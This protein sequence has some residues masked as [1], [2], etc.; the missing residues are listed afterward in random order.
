MRPQARVGDLLLPAAE[1]QYARRSGCDCLLDEEGVLALVLRRLGKIVDTAKG[2]IF[3]RSSEQRRV[4]VSYS[5][6]VF[7]GFVLVRWPSPRY[8][9]QSDCV[10]IG[11]SKCFLP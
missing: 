7:H 4:K 5:S 2:N 11:K 3:Y 9:A 8:F 6:H 1:D 10:K